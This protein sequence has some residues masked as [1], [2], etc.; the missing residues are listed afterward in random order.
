MALLRFVQMLEHH[1]LQSTLMGALD[2]VIQKHPG[3]PHPDKSAKRRRLRKRA[4][5]A[6]DLAELAQVVVEGP[7]Q[8]S[9]L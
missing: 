4:E 2:H 7:D 9:P 3:N 5:Q 1:L 8:Q 6:K